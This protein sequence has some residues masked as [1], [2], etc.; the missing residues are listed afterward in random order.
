MTTI[1]YWDPYTDIAQAARVADRIFDQFFG[2]AG[3]AALEGS[4][5]EKQ[6]PTHQLPLDI[7]EGDGDY[8]LFA[9]VPGID[10]EKV[11]L[12]FDN[13]V[14]TIWAPADPVQVNGQW[15]RRE[16]SHGSY[17]RRLQ[18]PNEVQ[19]D[20][21]GA[22]FENG[23]LTVTVPKAA[24]PQPVKIPIGSHPRLQEESVSQS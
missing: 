18:L 3:S 7:L 9:S 5:P 23:V 16:R 6:P 11:E 13:G 21:I 22:S 10:P 4:G 17:S 20:R 14:L 24:R 12:T 1:R 19:S 15:I 8:T 2:S